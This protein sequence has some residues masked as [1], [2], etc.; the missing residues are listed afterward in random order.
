LH[1]DGSEGKTELKWNQVKGII[2]YKRNCYT[3]DLIC[4]GFAT[5]DGTVELSEEMDGWNALS[6]AVPRLLPGTASKAEWWHKVAKPP[7]AANPTTL[8][9][10]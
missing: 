1:A 5:P 6:D 3:V 2:A 9:S 8:F 7:L 10:R 4:M